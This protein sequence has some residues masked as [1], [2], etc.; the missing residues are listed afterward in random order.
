MVEHQSDQLWDARSSRVASTSINQCYMKH[1]PSV[2]DV[3]A[4]YAVSLS[5]VSGSAVTI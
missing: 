5:N 1:T 2:T 3:S 4:I